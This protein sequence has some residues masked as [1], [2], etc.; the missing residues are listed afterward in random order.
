MFLYLSALSTSAL[1]LVP[2][3]G[4]IAGAGSASCDADDDQGRSER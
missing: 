2:S 3:D 1:D 4:R